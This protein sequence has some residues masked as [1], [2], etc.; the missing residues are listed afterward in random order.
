MKLLGL[1][2]IIGPASIGKLQSIMESPASMATA[3][4]T[5]ILRGRAPSSMA[6]HITSKAAKAFGVDFHWQVEQLYHKAFA[7]RDV[8]LASRTRSGFDHDIASLK[9]VSGINKQRM[10]VSRDMAMN[11]LLDQA[12]EWIN[13]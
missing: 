4:A 5:G 7:E 1:S 13:W 2:P 3:A 9:S 6:P 10:Q 11:D 8:T 12:Q